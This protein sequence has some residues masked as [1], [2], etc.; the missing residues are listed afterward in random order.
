MGGGF[1]GARMGGFGGAGV[2]MGGAG[3]RGAAIGGPGVGFR[4]GPGIYRGAGPG[5]RT[6]GIRSGFVGGAVGPRWGGVRQAGWVGNRWAGR[7]W[8]GNRWAGS[9]WVGNRWAG[10]RWRG[11]WGGWGWGWGFPLA[12]ATVG[13]GYY[14]GYP[15]DNGCIAWD[16]Y[17]WID[18]CY[19]GYGGYGYW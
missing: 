14:G 1:G 5:F 19:A 10:N 8:V 15:Y 9:R 6:A 16:G 13:L 4:G 2:R 11:R 3:F 7:G 12:A 18:V 17:Q